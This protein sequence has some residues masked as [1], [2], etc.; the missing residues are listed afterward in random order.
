MAIALTRRDLRRLA[1]GHTSGDWEGHV[2]GRLSAMPQQATPLQLAQLLA[3]LSVG[4]EIIRLRL[5][6]GWLGGSANLG[7]ALEAIARGNSAGATAR[8][9]LLDAELATREDTELAPQTVLR[10]RGGILAIDE[11]LARHA[12]Y[13]DDGQNR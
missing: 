12:A 3:A 6:I 2:H 10:A 8:L 1:R 4:T 9:H 11:V 13:F 7:P 5:V